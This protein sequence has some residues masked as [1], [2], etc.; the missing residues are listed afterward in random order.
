M[1]ALLLLMACRPDVPDEGTGLL[2]DVRGS[3]AKLNELNEQA[4][5]SMARVERLLASSADGRGRGSVEVANLKA[6]IAALRG[7]IRGLEG[8][9][10]WSWGSALLHV[11]TFGASKPKP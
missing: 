1:T 10:E 4:K 7:Q 2:K 3:L 5:S 8:R 11:V 9:R 6:E